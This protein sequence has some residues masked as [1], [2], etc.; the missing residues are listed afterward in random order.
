MQAASPS[1]QSGSVTEEALKGETAWRS[2]LVLLSQP[3]WSSSHE[4]PLQ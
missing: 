3:A 4:I 2:V 1:G